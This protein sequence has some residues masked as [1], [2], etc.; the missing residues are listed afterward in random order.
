MWRRLPIHW[1][2]RKI[3]NC[4]IG[5][6]AAYV[7]TKGHAFIDRALYLPKARTFDPDRLE[8]AHVPCGVRFAT[9]PAVAAAMA[10]RAMSAEVPFAWV[11]ADSVD[12]VG[13]LEMTLRR[14]AKSRGLGVNANH[15]FNS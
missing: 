8:A 3:T 11:A 14:Q 12:G 6:F 1:L 9:K 4:R 10:M 7:S 13:E 2:S 5:V 15:Q